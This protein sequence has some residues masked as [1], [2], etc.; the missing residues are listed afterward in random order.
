[1]PYVVELYR[2]YSSSNITTT[3]IYDGT[4][5]QA[6]D[7]SLNAGGNDIGTLT[8]SVR[9]NHS[10]ATSIKSNVL[11]VDT[12]VSLIHKYDGHPDTRLF[13]G[14]IVGYEQGIDGTLTVTCKDEF[15]VLDNAN[16]RLVTDLQ[17]VSMTLKD[18]GVSAMT[19][20]NSSRSPAFTITAIREVYGYSGVSEQYSTITSSSSSSNALG[21]RTHDIGARDVMT[22]FD[23]F[24]LIAEDMDAVMRM[25][26][27]SFDERILVISY[28]TENA[29]AHTY[30]Y[31]ESLIDC[32]VRY[33]SDDYKNAVFM[34]GGNDM[35]RESG[36][37][38]SV[39]LSTAGKDGDDI[40]KISGT[41]TNEIYIGTG[42][43][44]IYSPSTYGV[45]YHTIKSPKQIGLRSGVVTTIS[46][47]P[48][49]QEDAASGSTGHYVATDVVT[50]DVPA[51]MASGTGTTP[52][53]NMAGADSDK[54]AYLRAST[55][56]NRIRMEGTHS[57]SS[58]I[59]DTKLRKVAYSILDEYV[60]T[61]TISRSI[62]VAFVEKGLT[63]DGYY[64][65]NE[66]SHTYVGEVVHV[67]HT[68]IDVD[69]DLRV[70]AMS[71]TVGEPQSYSYTVGKPRKT[72]TGNIKKL[73]KRTSGLR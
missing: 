24:K 22:F 12:Q 21:N 63:G 4:D 37:T 41:S 33:E 40:V 14:Y 39:S 15:F 7:V 28:A 50:K 43:V 73:D 66:S 71:L 20:Y 68:G 55:H 64:S 30:A 17:G 56:L 51:K 65:S 3:T 31:G 59:S 48:P 1:M 45:T 2:K 34:S 53:G 25:R 5:R 46:I 62:D 47:D 52:A 23:A 72:I 69:D 10:A 16:V 32:T 11:S 35:T 49:L 60:E 8:F 67:R 54:R 36:T 26:Y 44:F 38:R 27:V 29:S 42:D 6:W 13:T 58:I 70:N 18:I 19:E 61:A 9:G 57:D